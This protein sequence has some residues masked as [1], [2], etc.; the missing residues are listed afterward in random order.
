MISGSFPV[1]PPPSYDNQGGAAMNSYPPMNYPPQNYPAPNQYGM[2]PQQQQQAV[3][4]SV[5]LLLHLA[6]SPPP[7]RQ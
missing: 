5:F 6:R 2:Q 4:V 7:P 1:D 3:V